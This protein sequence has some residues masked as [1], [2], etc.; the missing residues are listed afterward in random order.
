VLLRG[1]GWVNGAADAMAMLGV[2]AGGGGGGLWIEGEAEVELE[3][4]GW[5]VGLG[6]ATGWM[7]RG[8]RV[9]GAFRW[10][11]GSMRRDDGEGWL[12]L[13]RLLL[14]GGGRGGIGAAGHGMAQ[15]EI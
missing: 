11:G 2:V 12:L 5:R 8:R 10:A 6:G 9:G 7:R 15:A 13:G 3:R 4:M 1:Q 14:A